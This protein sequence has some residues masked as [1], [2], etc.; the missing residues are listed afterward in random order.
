ME[1]Q[2]MPQYYQK[3][4]PLNKDLHAEM[5]V[6]P[7]P[8]GFRFTASSQTVLLAH[9]E[10]FDAGR[11]F[12]IIFIPT[13]TNSFVPVALLGLEPNENLFVDAEGSWTAQYVPAYIRRYPFIT[14]D[15]DNDRLAICFDETFP[16]FKQEGGTPLFIDG[17]ASPKL[18][19]IQTFLQDY[20]VQMKQ[21]EQFG[22][23]LAQSGLLRQMDAQA[24]LSDGRSFPLNGLLVVDEQK[25]QQLPDADVVGLFRS[26]LMAVI[27]A[28]LM[29]L[30]NLNGLIDR[31]VRLSL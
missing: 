6:S 20:A 25:L 12:P 13:P 9:A 28:H 24:N 11:H 17:E 26:G 1:P 19:E 29:S 21:T 5:T 15:V 7:G 16:G 30:R 10:F 27:Q 8:D 18:Q 23:M 2:K 22:T 31:K 3:L 4:V 14:A